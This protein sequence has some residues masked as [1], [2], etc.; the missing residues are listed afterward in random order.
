M[1]PSFDFG[2]DVMPHIVE[3][4]RKMGSRANPEPRC[5]FSATPDMSE[6]AR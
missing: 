6:A 3:E 4:G 1:V 2:V 5:G